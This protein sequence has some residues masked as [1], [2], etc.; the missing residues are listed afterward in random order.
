MKHSRQWFSIIFALI[1]LVI[2]SSM[3]LYLLSFI[4]PYSKNVKWLENSSKA[5]YIA[6]S[7]IEQ[8][9]WDISQNDLWYETTT[10][11]SGASSYSYSIDSQGDQIPEPKKGNSNFDT[12]WNRIWYADPIQLA[13]G[14]DLV[15][16]WGNIRFDFRVPDL[17]QDG[18]FSDQ[19][20][21]GTSNDIIVTWQLS[22][23]SDSLIPSSTGAFITSPDINTSSSFSLASRPWVTLDSSPATI[24]SFYTN[25][26]RS[27][28]LCTLK[29]SVI[30]DLSVS[31]IGATPIPYLEYQIDTSGQD[32]PTRFTQIESS[33]RSFWF[34]K[35]ITSRVAQL[36]TDQAFDFAVFQ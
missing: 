6:S 28:E 10:T 19:L 17:D 20:I 7:G 11:F 12:D 33:G 29:L 18:N 15:S 13:I 16:N 36:T 34:Q 8:A 1:V 31:D 2:A 35:D 14:D 21:A 26:C 24:S 22:S 9:L 25:N 32:I 30:G 5:Y 3:S 23:S 4:V 27:G